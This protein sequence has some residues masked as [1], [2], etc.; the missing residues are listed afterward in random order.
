MM[1]VRGLGICPVLIV[2]IERMRVLTPGNHSYDASRARAFYCL[3]V[4]GWTRSPRDY[5]LLFSAGS[6]RCL[7]LS[8][9]HP[10]CRA[11]TGPP[12]GPARNP[13]PRGSLVASWRVEMS[14]SDPM[15]SCLRRVVGS[16]CAMHHL[17]ILVDASC[18]DRVRG[19]P[20]ESEWMSCSSPW[21]S[22]KK[23]NG[24]DFRK[25]VRRKT[26]VV[27]GQTRSR[28]MIHDPVHKLT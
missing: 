11:V 17:H 20:S 27:K 28:D 4:R 18:H 5:F 12:L 1:D 13:T 21:R 19:V 8:I 9:D 24:I 16:S 22:E 23:K 25:T 26:S 2:M 6:A 14:H 7:E 10:A 15:K 3:V